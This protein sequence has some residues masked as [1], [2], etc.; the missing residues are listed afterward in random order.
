MVIALSANCVYIGISFAHRCFSLGRKGLGVGRER[1]EDRNERYREREGERE[2]RERG[3]RGVY[4][5]VCVCGGDE[6]QILN[7]LQLSPHLC[8]LLGSSCW[9]QI[10]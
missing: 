9:Y 8:S 3:E 2:K 7:K 4:K 1:R 6:N 10:S 5:I